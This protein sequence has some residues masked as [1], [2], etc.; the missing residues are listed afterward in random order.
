MGPG[1]LLGQ[2]HS[3]QGVRGTPQPPGDSLPQSPSQSQAGMDH[4]HHNGHCSVSWSP[5]GCHSSIPHLLGWNKLVG[6]QKKRNKNVKATLSTIK[7]LSTK[8][9]STDLFLR[10]QR[11]SQPTLLILSQFWEPSWTSSW[12]LLS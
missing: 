5:P 7:G 8:L 4:C 6:L 10:Q 9:G 11:Y 12:P 1:L 3:M 2:L